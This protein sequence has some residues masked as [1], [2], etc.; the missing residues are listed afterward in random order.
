MIPSGTSAGSVYTPRNIAFAFAEHALM[1]VKNVDPFVF[2]WFQPTSNGAYDSRKS[3]QSQYHCQLQRA[4]N[5][6]EY[7]LLT[8]F[9]GGHNTYT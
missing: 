8:T 7:R 1:L 2:K 6:A 4:Y 5:L 3:H 9:R